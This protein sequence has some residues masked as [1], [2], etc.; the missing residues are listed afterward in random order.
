MEKLYAVTLFG[1]D[2]D[3]YPE[4]PISKCTTTNVDLA[5]NEFERVGKELIER[6]FEETEFCRRPENKEFLE[7]KRKW[8]ASAAEML[9][10][11][12]TRSRKNGIVYRSFGYDMQWEYC[13]SIEEVK[14][15]Q[16]INTKCLH[17]KWS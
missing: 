13:V 17:D 1:P 8:K 15:N 11:M 9:D 7:K 2:G 16:P 6:F 14:L 3:H 4:I 10:K 12:V 5:I